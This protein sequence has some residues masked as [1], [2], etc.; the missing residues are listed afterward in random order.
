MEK[1]I[2]KTA[3]FRFYAELND[4][5]PKK[6]RYV[7]FPLTFKNRQ[8]VKHLIESIGVPHPE[9]DLILAGSEPRDFSYIVQDKDVISVY[10]V[11]ESFDISTENKLRPEPLREPK[12]VLDSHLGRLAAYLRLLGIDSLYRNDYADEEITEISHNENRICLTRDRG[13]LKRNIITRGYC[14][15]SMDSRQQVKEVLRRF[16]LVRKVK[17]FQRC[18]HC[19]G[20]LEDVDKNEIIDQLL[21]KTK[22]YY[23]EFRRCSE[24]GQVYWKGSHFK[25]IIKLIEGLL[26]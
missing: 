6:Q 5:L 17:P 16:D 9:V 3:Y 26:E 10:P 15:R 2:I 8:S 12:F 21:P 19:N 11:F 25:R 18:V 4:F 7:L 24:C 20:M 13:L 14:L 22:Q 1:M 23:D